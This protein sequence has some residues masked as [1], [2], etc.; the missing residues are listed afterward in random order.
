LQ[1]LTPWHSTVSAFADEPPMCA[2]PAAIATAVNAAA[3]KVAF[4]S[5]V[6]PEMNSPSEVSA[7]GTPRISPSFNK[8]LT[9]PSSVRDGV[10]RENPA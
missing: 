10:G 7:A 2:Q 5:M 3:V 6:P 8:F 9:R 1:P 4:R